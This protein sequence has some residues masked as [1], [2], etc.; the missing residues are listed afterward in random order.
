M[1]IYIDKT[2]LADD[3]L[4]RAGPN[5]TAFQ[6]SREFN[7]QVA[8]YVRADAITIFD[9]LN[10]KTEFSFSTSRLYGS[11]L[12]AEAGMLGLVQSIPHF[13]TIMI[14]AGGTKRF[15]IENAGIVITSFNFVGVTTFMSYR[16][17]GGQLQIAK[18]SGLIGIA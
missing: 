3:S 4:G 12:D 13:G 7:L 5:V 16:V 2:V 10:V 14:F 6:G 8:E 17:I 15:Y 9:R 18:P 1:K 11:N